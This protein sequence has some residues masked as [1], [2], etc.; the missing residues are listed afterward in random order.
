MLKILKIL[1]LAVEDWGQE[2]MLPSKH[3]EPGWHQKLFIILDLFE[4]L[5]LK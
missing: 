2:L 4:D 1:V 5:R 3:Y